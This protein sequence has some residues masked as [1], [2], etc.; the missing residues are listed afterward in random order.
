MGM[1]TTEDCWLHRFTNVGSTHALAHVHEQTTQ[2]AR[3]RRLLPHVLAQVPHKTPLDMKERWHRWMHWGVCLT[4]PQ[5][6]EGT[7]PLFVVNSVKLH[8]TACT[9][10]SDRSVS[11][12]QIIAILSIGARSHPRQAVTSWIGSIPCNIVYFLRTR[13]I[14][15]SIW[16]LTLA[17]F[18]VSFTS[19]GQLF[20]AS[21][22]CCYMKASLIKT[23]SV[24]YIKAPIS[25]HYV[26]R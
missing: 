10:D 7:Q 21:C 22:K 13:P 5:T 2:N 15:L 19:C 18:L 16:I 8:L 26:P 14:T 3:G 23:H 1:W 25:K 11:A 9:T 12:Q 24:S 4:N 6:L 17:I 20:F